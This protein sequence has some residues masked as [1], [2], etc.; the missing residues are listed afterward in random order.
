MKALI[1]EIY[2]K[3]EILCRIGLGMLTLATDKIVTA[4]HSFG[5]IT[6]IRAAQT[7]GRVKA[8]LA[9]DPW[10][11]MHA[12]DANSGLMKIER[13][14]FTIMTENFPIMC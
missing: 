10:M 6:A 2:S 4:G 14:L 9:F 1:E 13:P 11:L 3:A 12:T 8:V 5:G 7:D